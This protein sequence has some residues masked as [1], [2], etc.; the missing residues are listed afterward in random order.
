MEFLQT[1]GNENFSRF[2]LQGAGTR[3]DI[4]RESRE[5]DVAALNFS[6]HIVRTTRNCASPLIIRAYASFA[7]SRG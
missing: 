4:R 1:G 7:F 2:C 3:G 5:M 6:N